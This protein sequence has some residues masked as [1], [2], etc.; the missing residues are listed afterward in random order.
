MKRKI[1]EK[2][3]KWKNSKNRKPLICEGVRQVGK[4]YSLREFGEKYY[5]NVI[6]VNFEINQTIASY[7]DSDIEPQKIIRFLEVSFGEKIEKENTLIF[8]DEI[9][10]SERALTS[11]KYF[12][13]KVPE[14]HIVAAGSLLG[15]AINREK[16]SFP[17]GKVDIIRLTPLDFEEFLWAKGKELLAEEIKH[18]FSSCT[19]LPDALH[20]EALEIYREYLIVGGMPESVLTFVKTDSYIDVSNIQGTILDSYISDMAKYSSAS[21]SVKIRACFRSIPAQLAKDNKKF[22]YK[23]IQK[24]ASSSLFGASIEWLNFAGL[25]LKCQ[26][27]NHAYEPLNAYSDLS[28]FKLYLSDV[29][30]LTTLSGISKQT[31]LSGEPN[32]FMGALTENYVAECLLSNGYDLFYWES[33][34]IAELDFVLQ[35]ESEIIALE[36]KKGEH[37]R[38]RSLSVFVNTYKP[39]Y[40]IRLSSKNF[41]ESDNTK[42]I[43]LYAAFCI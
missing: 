9:Q 21:D 37:V 23:V 10:A 5:K 2:L 12:Y 13:E 1:E 32:V 36:V 18:S 30:L 15:V 27:I 26:K 41:G 20:Y 43:P 8:F 31:I 11:L 29:G 35:K 19:P 34:S 6:Y 40:S 28:S 33:N 14:Y 22:Q 16:Y 25:V 4:T 3:L 24:G 42:Y 39:T 7:F 38:S 17:V